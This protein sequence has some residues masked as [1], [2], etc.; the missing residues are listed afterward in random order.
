MTHVGPRIDDAEVAIGADCE[1]EVFTVTI[2]ANVEANA[3][4]IVCAHF[5]DC[6][7]GADAIELTS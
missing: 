2:G 1:V 3:S 7:A 6:D 5:A 4:C